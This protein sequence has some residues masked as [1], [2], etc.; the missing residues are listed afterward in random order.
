MRKIICYFFILYSSLAEANISLHADIGLMQ[1][2]NSIASRNL[3]ENYFYD[4]SIYGKVFQRTKIYFGFEYVFIS[5]SNPL[6]VYTSAVL[7][8]SNPMVGIKYVAGKND[9]IAMSLAGSPLTAATYSVTG[10]NSEEW[11]GTAVMAKISLQPELSNSVRANMSIAY[12]SANYSTRTSV[13]S[14]S[15]NVSSFSRNLLVPALGLSYFF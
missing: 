11:S 10:L 2:Q 8:S 3:V 15:S 1:D 12:F 5:S 6:T 4:L 9:L 14:S 7:T 13:A